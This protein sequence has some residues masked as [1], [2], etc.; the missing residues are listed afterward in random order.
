[1]AENTDFLFGTEFALYYSNDIVNQ[2]KEIIVWSGKICPDGRIT[3]NTRE[4]M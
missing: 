4:W 1:M 2:R 3:R